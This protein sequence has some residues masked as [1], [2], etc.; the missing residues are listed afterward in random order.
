MNLLAIATVI[1]LTLALYVVMGYAFRGL[2]RLI[3][4][5]DR[6][7]RQRRTPHA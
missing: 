2:D 3:E 4:W 7:V 6:W 1:L 5:A